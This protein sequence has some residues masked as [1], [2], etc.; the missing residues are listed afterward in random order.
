MVMCKREDRMFHIVTSARRTARRLAR[1]RAGDTV[2]RVV[3]IYLLCA[4]SLLAHLVNW[5]PATYILLGV[6]AAGALATAPTVLTGALVAAGAVISV[7]VVAFGSRRLTATLPV[8]VVAGSAMFVASPTDSP[9]ASAA[10]TVTDPAQACPNSDEQCVID[11]YLDLYERHGIDVAIAAAALEEGRVAGGPMAYHCHNVMHALGRTMVADGVPLRAAAEVAENYG[12][13]CNAGFIHGVFEGGVAAIPAAEVTAN[14]ETLCAAYGENRSAINT[15]CSHVLGHVLTRNAQDAWL[16]AL[17]VCQTVQTGREMC[18]SGGFME[19][20]ISPEHMARVDAGWPIEKALSPCDELPS[21]WPL[22]AHQYC[23]IEASPQLYKAVGGDV[24]RAFDVCD[25]QARPDVLEWCEMGVGKALALWNLN[26]PARIT[27]DCAGDE[28]CLLWGA[29]M[30]ANV[31]G[32]AAAGDTVCAAIGDE[33]GAAEC[34]ERVRRLSSYIDGD[35]K[36]AR[37]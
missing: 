23:T 28:R 18:W 7:L 20:F 5:R 30:L 2:C 15:Y 25:E 16:D 35:N 4:A 11:L 8:V 17:S 36:F 13:M 24:Q 12:P 3:A 21:H 32:S 31:M 1:G 14:A 9:I 29:Q 27:D 22:E 33:A 10:V 34:R 6:L 26:D 37:S 19:Y